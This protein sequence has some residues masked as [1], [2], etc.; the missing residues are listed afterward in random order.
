ME[1]IAAILFALPL[2]YYVR[3][4]RRALTIYLLLWATVFP[5]QTLA[6]HSDNP[7]DLGVMYFVVNAV[8]LAAGLG[9]N[10]VGARL[11]ERR[12]AAPEWP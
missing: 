3:T 4:R 1:L 2:G 6:V 11:R 12:R 8:I 7:E 9:L 5:V 10:T